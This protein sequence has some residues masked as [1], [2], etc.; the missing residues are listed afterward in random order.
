M[1]NRKN[2]ITSQPAAYEPH[3]NLKYGVYALRAEYQFTII[4]S[5]FLVCAALGTIVIIT[6]L[7]P[8]SRKPVEIETGN[9]KEIIYTMSTD[10]PEPPAPT[11][12]AKNSGAA[13]P[14]P[15]EQ[16][17]AITI[18]DDNIVTET[19]TTFSTSSTPQNTLSGSAS[20]DTNT[21]IQ[22]AGS[23]T[24]SSGTQ[25]STIA[26]QFVV[27]VMPEFEGGLKAL[28]KFIAANVRYPEPAHEMGKEGTV[29]VQFVVDT[30]GNISQ[31][32]LLNHAGFGL[33]EEA[34][35]VIGLLPK[36]KSPGMS[37][38]VPV[39]VYYNVPIKFRIQ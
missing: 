1:E 39:S 13:I 8:G 28:H 22:S 37:K 14:P 5:L 26:S 4:K 35:R 31:I 29:H 30:D 9:F 32:T 34:L 6:R 25:R 27:D 24:N 11:E 12:T 21:Q 10:V 16:N 17:R 38:G 3:S 33:D 18:T 2:D 20:G 15:A 19:V 7:C 36:F 23:G